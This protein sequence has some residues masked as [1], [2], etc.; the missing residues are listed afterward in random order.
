ME[1]KKMNHMTLK[2]TQCLLITGILILCATPG[3]A[4][5]TSLTDQEMKGV[6][7]Q[8][9]LQMFIED[10][11]TEEQKRE[12]EKNNSQVQALMALNGMIPS[13]LL[14]D[15]QNIRHTVNDSTR[16]VREFNT[17]QKD[18]LVVPTATAITTIINLPSM[19]I[20]GFGGFF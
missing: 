14:R 5:L 6:T 13:E 16:I 11:L 12:Q 2:M 8:S 15:M 9:G 10:G 19:G 7:G 4:G 1:K 17:I 18:L 3:F 20:G